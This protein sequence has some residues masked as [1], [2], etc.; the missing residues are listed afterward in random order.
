[1]FVFIIFLIIFAK[2]KQNTNPKQRLNRELF[3]KEISPIN[4]LDFIKI[5]PT[6][7]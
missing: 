5:I 1:M 3:S 7:E 4:Q 2:N 6:M